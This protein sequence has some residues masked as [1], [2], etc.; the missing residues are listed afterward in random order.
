MSIKETKKGAII[1]F[2]VKPKAKKF[3][4]TVDDTKIVV[5]CKE[6][7]VRGKVNKEL[8]KEFSK[9]FH[10]KVELVSGSSSKRKRLLIVG[11]DK[12]KIEQLFS[13]K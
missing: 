4:I 11:V 2:L 1:E 13:V 8:A 12:S 7:P 5:S 3:E 10:A 6:Q 9:L